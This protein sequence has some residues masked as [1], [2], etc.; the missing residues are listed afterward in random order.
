MSLFQKM[1]PKKKNN[2][3]S[4]QE[5]ETE[6][7]MSTHS[8]EDR[9]NTDNISETSVGSN[10]SNFSPCGKCS[11]LVKNEDSAMQCEIC[12]KWFHIKCQNTTIAEYNYIKGGS[13][14]KSLS[15]MHWYCHTC[16]RMTVNLSKP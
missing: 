13:K 12:E 15:K 6:R 10:H 7:E 2:K 4:E 8:V 5:E 14:N 16:D 3:K 9:E 11:K 1:T